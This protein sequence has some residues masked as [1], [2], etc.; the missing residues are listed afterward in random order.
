[1]YNFFLKLPTLLQEKRTDL[2][3]NSLCFSPNG[4]VLW[5]H[6]PWITESDPGGQL[7]TEPAAGTESG[8]HLDIVVA[9]VK[10]MLS[11]AFKIIKF[12]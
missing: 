5:I 1:M 12:Y 4:S 8:Y 9:I 3:P 10:N 2:V 6:N 11:N 7:I